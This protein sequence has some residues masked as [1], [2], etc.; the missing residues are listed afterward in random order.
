MASS[1]EKNPAE[2]L[3]TVARR[4]RGEE[5]TGCGKI[6][7]QRKISMAELSATGSRGR[8]DEWGGARSSNDHSAFISVGL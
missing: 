3:V 7:Q 8:Q 6:I 1:G 4:H 5:L 2:H